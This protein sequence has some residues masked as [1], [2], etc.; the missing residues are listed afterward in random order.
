MTVGGENTINL[1]PDTAED[2]HLFFFGPSGVRRVI[3]GPVITPGLTGED[4]AGLIGIAANC[5][6][7]F[8]I[9]IEKLI[10]RLGASLRKID[11]Q[12]FDGFDREGMNVAAWV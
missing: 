6:D 11:P 8:H 9:L 5:D 2:F 12:F 4:G 7:R 1:I 3:E 10:E